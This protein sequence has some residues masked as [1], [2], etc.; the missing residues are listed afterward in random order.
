MDKSLLGVAMITKENF[1]E[2]LYIL[3]FLPN[4]NV[5]KCESFEEFSKAESFAKSFA[6]QYSL[7]VDFRASK[8]IYPEKLTI[9]DTTTCNF[10]KPENF[11]VFECV[12]RLLQKGYHPEHIELEPKWALGRE[13][14]GGK[15]DIFVKDRENK[16]YLLI[17]CKTSPKYKE[18]SEFSKEWGRMQND[19]G[20]LFSYFQQERECK[21][22]CLYTSDLESNELIY[23]N[24]IIGVE[25]NKDLLTQSK[26]QGYKDAYTTIELV[27]VWKETYNAE[28]Q[29]NGIFEEVI[30]AY[31]ITALKP[32]F[33][34]LKPMSQSEIQ[35]KRHEWATI[36][37][38]NAVGDRTLALNKLM[39]LFLCKITDE[40]ENKSD[41]QFNWNGYSKDS[42][43]DLVDRLQKLYKIGMDKYLSQNITYHSKNSI[44]QAFSKDFKDIIIKE[45]IQNIFNELK[46]FSNGDFNFIEVYN[47]ALFDKNFK[48]LLPIVQSLQ[49]VGFTKEADSNILGDY[50]ESYIHD[51]PQQEGQYF[52]PVPL[53]NFIIHSLPV[54]KN[55]KVLD[56]SCGAGHFLTQY[57]EL[58]KAYDKAYFLGI[59]KDQRLAKIAKIASFMHQTDMEIYSYD[60]LVKA[61]DN[62]IQHQKAIPNQSFNVLISNPPYSVDGF[63][64]TLDK[65]SQRDYEIFKDNINIESNN[66]IECFF[67]EKSAK[68]LQSNGILALVLPNSL[69]NKEGIYQ[70]T[71]EL[72]LREFHIIAI[73]ELANA[74]FFKTGTNPI[75]LFALRKATDSNTKTSQND[76]FKDFYRLIL[77][78]NFLS[79]IKSYQNFLPLLN[80]YCAF[81]DYDTQEFEALLQ[82]KLPQDSALFE[83][84][85]FK[86]YV[87]AY[88]EFVEKEKTEYEKKSN[89]FKEN[90]PFIPSKSKE[91]FIREIECEKFL[92]F[93]YCQDSSPI[94][95]KAPK[96]NKEQKKFLGYEWSN[97]KGKQGIVY[98]NTNNNSISEIQT[99]LYNPK[100]RLDSN[101]LNFYILQEYINRLEFA[102]LDE[103]FC[104]T[105]EISQIP[106]HLSPFAFRARL[107][108]LIDFSRE[109]FNKAISLNHTSSVDRISNPFENSKYE[110][111]KIA[112]CGE[113]I[114]G[115]WKGKKEPFIK[116]RVIRNTNFSMK[117]N[118]KLDSEYP[119]LEVEV[120]QF[121][122]RKLEYG[123][124]IIE[125]SGGSNTQAVGR[126]VIFDFKTKELYS[127]S[128]FTNRL[129]VKNQT[130]NPFYL[131]L[132]LNYIYQQGVTFTIQSGMSGLRNLDMNAYKNLKIPLPPL[133]I[134]K[135]IVS[136][137]EKVEEQYNTIRMSIEEYQK[138]IK[139]I[140][141]K[142]GI[143]EAQ[144][145]QSANSS[146]GG[147]IIPLLVA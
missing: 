28:S 138:L 39:N 59:D 97:T 13:A 25:D 121:E 75:I 133:E 11:V 137:C 65:D 51:M 29:D 24:Y 14:K 47:K 55:A 135:Q 45:K 104:Y 77:E 8:L 37:R 54:L 118:L 32:T 20:Q 2:L 38:A 18:K 96:D 125:K 70:S 50:F 147:G 103:G 143:C 74:T 83:N 48:I 114:G 1:K 95:I 9:N 15:A 6:E 136:E 35:K 101:K 128:N 5:G 111:V 76:I 100:E 72:L 49:N 21:F 27:R 139:A 105:N 61:Q 86:E 124:I 19:G 91:I 85:T 82:L 12:H 119:E 106:E 127:F 87:N 73:C 141:V 81:Q 40:L 80:A 89:K 99:P 34:N 56:F 130:I 110:L 115:L 57:A 22:L 62:D 117:G 112:D 144:N 132:V 92:Y 31:G 36:L 69:L 122:K 109:S 134:Q 90:N 94:I 113:F 140:L 52:T 116:V 53:V 108:E 10:A 93:C 107:V 30:L 42:A 142:C 4:D 60:S 26:K 78:N 120:G 33:E 145:M 41:L 66:A 23:K 17:E 68:A 146:G 43:F 16:P 126:V 102:L 7:K 64:E 46:F 79:L 88:K 44:E 129:R 131:H 84:E 58:N 3:G 98:L 71:R 123:D 67:I 63:L